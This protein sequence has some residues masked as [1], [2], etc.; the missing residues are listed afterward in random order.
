[1]ISDPALDLAATFHAGFNF[2]RDALGCYQE[3]NGGDGALGTRVERHRLLREL[4]GL[5]FV[6]R[7]DWE[8]EF[9]DAV[10]KV[11]ALLVDS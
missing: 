2:G 6:I 11:R 9:P 10:S 4:A 5:Q 3:R 1:M 7:H 8:A